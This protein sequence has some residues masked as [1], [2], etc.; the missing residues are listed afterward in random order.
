MVPLKIDITT[1]DKITPKEIEYT[2]KLM[3][4]DRNISFLGYNL[5]TILAE[6][7]ETIISRGDQN[8]RPRDFYDIYI[9]SKLQIDNIDY[10]ELKLALENTTKKRGSN[11]IIKEYRSIMDTIKNSYI[12]KSQWNNYKNNFD[13]A[14]EIDFS[15]V[16]DTVKLILEK[17]YN[18]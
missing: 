2:H 6:K 14:S 5:S 15:E 7:L 13:Y 4:E 3:F 12:M 17:L 10:D 11:E 16:C 8:T 1:G 9:L 18:K